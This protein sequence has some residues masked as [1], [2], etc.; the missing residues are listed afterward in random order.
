M[1]GTEDDAAE[2]DVASD[3]AFSAR[4]DAAGFGKLARENS[5][6]ERTR[7][8]LAAVHHRAQAARFAS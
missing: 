2:Q 1:A 8:L 4:L 6:D 3:A 5:N 7:E